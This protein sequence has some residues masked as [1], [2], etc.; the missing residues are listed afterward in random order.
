MNP[1]LTIGLPIHNE[2][3][4]LPHLHSLLTEVCRGLGQE[5]EIL[6]VDDGSSDSSPQLLR[7]IAERDARTTVA[8]LT[9]NFGHPA[10]LAA[11]I[12]LA[13][14]ESLV[15][16]DADLQDDPGSSR[17]CCEPSE[18]KGQRSSM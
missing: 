17:R 18:N 2:A 11:A 10:A 6:Y 1:P 8:T 9:R 15:L 16:M 13:R 3:K 5:Y 14:G 4:I 12:D 7:E